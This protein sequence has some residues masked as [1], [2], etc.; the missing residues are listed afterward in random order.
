MESIANN[1]EDVLLD[2]LSFKV[3]GSGQYVVDRR[4]AP[5][6]TEGSNRYREWKALK[7]IGHCHAFCRRLRI[8]VRGHSIEDIQDYN[9]VHHMFNILQGPQVRL[10]EECEGFW[11]TDDAEGLT[12]PLS[13]PGIGGGNGTIC[14]SRSQAIIFKQLCGRFQQT[15]YIPLRYCPMTNLLVQHV[16]LFLRLWVLPKYGILNSDKSSVIS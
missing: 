9:R 2:S 16:E 1:V 11:Y 12:S 14:Y 6:H 15:K 13:M 5:F 3:S 8:S 7:P 4:S 10:N